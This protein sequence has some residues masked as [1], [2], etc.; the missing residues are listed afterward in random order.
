MTIVLSKAFALTHDTAVT[1]LVF[2]R[3]M[4]CLSIKVDVD[5]SRSSTK[6]KEVRSTIKKPKDTGIVHYLL[7]SSEH[8]ADRKFM[9][10]T[11]IH[12]HQV[13]LKS[14]YL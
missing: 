8:A 13:A 9:L 5:E 10:F 2:L 1:L 12:Y 4:F 7:S 11:F 6:F 3:L 14:L